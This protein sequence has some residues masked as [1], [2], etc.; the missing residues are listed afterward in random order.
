MPSHSLISR[1]EVE[2]FAVKLD[3]LT[4]I[5]DEYEDCE[6]FISEGN[7]LLGQLADEK[8]AHSNIIAVI[9]KVF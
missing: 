5:H 2:V 1:S 8:K 3:E 7:Q 6:K 4:E 9:D